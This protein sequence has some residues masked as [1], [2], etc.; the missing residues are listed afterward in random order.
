[1]K[2]TLLPILLLLLFGCQRDKLAGTANR[3]KATA[4]LFKLLDTVETGITFANF[5][6]DTGEISVFNNLYMYNGGGVAVGDI[7]G[8]GLQD[9]FFTSNQNNGCLYLN[10]GSFK[11]KNLTASAGIDTRGGWTTGVVMADVNA[12]GLADIYVC[13]GG[14][15]ATGNTRNLLFINQGNLAF[16]ESAAEYGIDDAGYSTQASFF[17]YDNDGDLD[18][19]VMNYPSLDNDPLNFYGYKTTKSDYINS[20]H[21]YI[22]NENHFTDITLKANLP[23][24]KAYGLGLVISDINQDG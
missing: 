5:V 2:K 15:R 3:Q 23:I 20:D 21:L 8:D 9:I 12:D 22:N 13:R 7:N 16:K 4:P 24:E 18:L 10:L 17:D 11:F 6:N 19:Y 14:S 1:M